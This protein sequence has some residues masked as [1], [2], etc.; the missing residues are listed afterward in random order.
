MIQGRNLIHHEYEYEDRVHQYV[1][2]IFVF[3]NCYN[4]EDDS[5]TK[6]TPEY[7]WNCLHQPIFRFWTYL[8]PSKYWAKIETL[9]CG[10][11]VIINKTKVQPPEAYVTIGRLWLPCLGHF[12]CLLSKIFKSYGFPVFWL[13][14]CMLK[15]FSKTRFAYWVR[16]RRF[17]LR[18]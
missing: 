18:E 13:C 12:V 9:P 2:Y 5:Y 8:L 10:K 17:Y 6:N 16:N 15:V 7:C 14:T 1:T 11:N 4:N 3:T